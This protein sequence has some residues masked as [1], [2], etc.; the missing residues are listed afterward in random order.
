[1]A[2]SMFDSADV[3]AQL[4]ARVP[5]LG[6]HIATIDLVPGFGLSVAKTGGPAHWSVWGRPLQLETC[7][8]DVVQASH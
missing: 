7:V 2:L 8:T 6:G 5:K 4:A 3:A 1:M